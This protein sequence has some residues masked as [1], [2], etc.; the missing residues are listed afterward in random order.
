M[1]FKFK[2]VRLYLAM[3]CI[4]IMAFLIGLPIVPKEKIEKTLKANNQSV[5]VEI[6]E[7][8]DEQS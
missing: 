5:V 4:G 8:A 7:A 2:Q 1:K 3:F 6:I